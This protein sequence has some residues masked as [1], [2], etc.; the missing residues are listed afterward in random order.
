MTQQLLIT[1]FFVLVG[2][3]VIFGLDLGAS[4]RIAGGII[5]LAIWC[6]ALLMH[7]SLLKQ[8]ALAGEQ[9]V[10]A[11][12]LIG[13]YRALAVWQVDGH[14]QVNAVYGCETAGDGISR[15]LL[16][17][18]DIGSLMARNPSLA[19]LV[20][21]VRSG[22]PSVGE[23]EINGVLYRHRMTPQAQEGEH[24][25]FT[26]I[27]EDLSQVR[28]EAETARLW[29]ALLEHTSDAVVVLDHHR[30]V[31]ATNSAFTTIT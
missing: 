2:I 23:A 22:L 18:R 15:A 6:A 29:N 26:C 19:A 7:R 28:G 30:V 24:F 3:A 14:G 27:S 16:L 21:R 13:R 1:F 31:V 10:G 4:D 12:S 20:Q 5:T 25:G 17:G 8:R 9:A 11:L